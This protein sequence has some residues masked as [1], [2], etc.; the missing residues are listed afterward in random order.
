DIFSGQPNRAPIEFE[1]DVS[2]LTVSPEGNV[3][4]ISDE[5]G[6]FPSGS[7]R[8]IL[9][10]AAHE[11][12]RNVLSET[13][14]GSGFSVSFSPDGRLLAS[15]GYRRKARLQISEVEAGHEIWRSPSYLHLGTEVAFSPDGKTLATWS[16]FPARIALLDVAQLLDPKLQRAAGRVE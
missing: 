2:A 15:G 7:C 14:A 1:R 11:R 5:R 13:S 12:L 4:A 6:L 9:Y 3:F 10:D 8:L 16:G